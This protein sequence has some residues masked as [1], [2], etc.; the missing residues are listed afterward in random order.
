MQSNELRGFEDVQ[1][2]RNW[3]E[4][5]VVE[6]LGGVKSNARHNTDVSSSGVL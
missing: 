3:M 1:S 4:G 5:K 6:M 2:Q